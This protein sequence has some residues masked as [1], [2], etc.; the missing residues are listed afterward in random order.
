MAAAV[1]DYRPAQYAETKIQ[2]LRNGNLDYRT[3][4]QSDI[5]AGLCSRKN[6]AV[7]LWIFS[8]KR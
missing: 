7:C 8:L 1:S 6:Q 4:A 3:V 5:L 2:R